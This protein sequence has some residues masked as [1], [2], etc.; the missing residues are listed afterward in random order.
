MS[1][2][3]RPNKKI[4][5]VK[6]RKKAWDHPKRPLSAYNFFFKDER[7]A[8]VNAVNEAMKAKKNPEDD[9]ENKVNDVKA[10]APAAS[11]KVEEGALKESTGAP[12]GSPEYTVSLDD[13]TVTRLVKGSGGISFEEIGKVIG[14]HWANVDPVRRA[15]YNEMAKVD[16]KRYNQEM[17]AYNLKVS[18]KRLNEQELEL[19]SSGSR[20]SD[21][22]PFHPSKVARTGEMARSIRPSLASGPS[23]FSSV[24]APGQSLASYGNNPYIMSQ[25]G[26]YYPQYVAQYGMGMPQGSRGASMSAGSQYGMYGRG[27]LATSNVYS[28]T[29]ST[30]GGGHNF[31]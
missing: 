5:P 31:R 21:G 9:A 2:D 15:K 7:K 30:G 24:V 19:G 26:V 8:I 29:G 1:V 17:D 28:S 18:A 6:K 12:E 16:R 20:I 27:A 4:P 25:R 11:I 13:E 23:A 14:Q 3:K 22:E 10:E